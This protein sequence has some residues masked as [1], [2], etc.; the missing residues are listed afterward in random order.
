[1]RIRGSVVETKGGAFALQELDIDEPRPTDILVKIVASGICQTDAH[2]RDQH[3]PVPLLS[4][5]G[6]LAHQP[7][8]V[9]ASKMMWEAPD[10]AD[11]AP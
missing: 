8:A 6:L 7:A 1:M 11:T 9:R 5:E 2:A 4:S 3:M 10:L